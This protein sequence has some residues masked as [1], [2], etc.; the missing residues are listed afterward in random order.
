MPSSASSFTGSVPTYYDR[1]LGP[2]L[3]EP[4]A[5]DLARRIGSGDRLRVL[6]IACGTGIVTRRLRGVLPASATLVAT[7]LN[8][9]MLRY[10]QAAVTEP[11]I[12]WQTA[13][14]QALPFADASFDA[15]VC[16]FGFMFLP[17]KP[18]GFREARRVLAPGGVLL[19]NV[20]HSMADN[21]YVLAF[22]AAFARLFPGDPPRFFETPYG[23]HNSDQLRADMAAGGWGQVQLEDVRMQSSSP[24]ATEFATGFVRGS[25]LTHELTQRGADLDEMIRELADS[26]VAVGGAH[27]FTAHLSA[28][29]IT[30][31]AGGPGHST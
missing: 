31:I 3:F 14:A 1:C 25:P 17:D 13:D 28:T 20:W 27:P 6:E 26:V 21:P 24:S 22:Q 9:A 2:V 5:A 16:Q 11:G 4:Y 19:A 15:V 7:D 23:Y 10:A 30:A 8:E 29:V 12:D 18:L